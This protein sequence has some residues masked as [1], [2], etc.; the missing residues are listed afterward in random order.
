MNTLKNINVN[1]TINREIPKNN[2]LIHSAFTMFLY[3]YLIPCFLLVRLVKHQELFILEL[4]LGILFLFFYSITNRQLMDY[5]IKTLWFFKKQELI[6]IPNHYSID[7]TI[8]I[9]FILKNLFGIKNSN[10]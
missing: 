7:K 4:A 9:T 1:A 3:Y 8:N 5:K 2:H 6:N 10:Q